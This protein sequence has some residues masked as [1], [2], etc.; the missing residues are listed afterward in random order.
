M[1]VSL[2][3]NG[4][5]GLREVT[6][7]VP[8]IGTLRELSFSGGTEEQLRTELLR[9]LIKEQDAFSHMTIYDRDYL[10]A[11]VVSSICLNSVPLKFMCPVCQAAGK[12][13]SCQCTYNIAEQEP[14]FLEEGTSPSIQKQWDFM[15]A[16]LT[17]RIL[18]VADEERIVAYALDDYDH[19]TLRYE[20]AFVAGVLGADLSTKDGISSGIALVNSYPVYVYF[21]VLLFNQLTFHGVP[22]YTEGVC[23]ECHNKTRVLVPFGS[24]VRELDSAK[25]VDRFAGLSGI[26]DFKSF[27]DL[28]FPELRQL[29]ESLASRLRPN[30]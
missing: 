28:S 14:V 25:I 26:I 5:L 8:R 21:S 6:V 30:Q 19:Y 20:Q 12:E 17:Y 15:D 22:Q 2:P 16:P 1:R 24:V 3:S 10:F 4:L 18:S 7:D 11:I 27:V 23:P 29:E 9:L 13:V